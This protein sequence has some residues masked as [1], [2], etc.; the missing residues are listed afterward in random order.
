MGLHRRVSKHDCSQRRESLI[1]YI[2]L[3]ELDSIYG[4]TFLVFLLEHVGHV[5]KM[6]VY[7]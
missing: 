2:S 7:G 4:I 5:A 1:T 6:S 3:R